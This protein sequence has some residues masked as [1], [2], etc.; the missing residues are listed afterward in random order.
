MTRR[1]QET[2]TPQVENRLEQMTKNAIS[3]TTAFITG[4]FNRER[5]NTSP[6]PSPENVNFDLTKQISD[7]FSGESFEMSPASIYQAGLVFKQFIL[8]KGVERNVL[9]KVGNFGNVISGMQGFEKELKVAANIKNSQALKDFL[10]KWLSTLPKVKNENQQQL[11][12][13]LKF[14][15][16]QIVESETLRNSSHIDIKD[17]LESISALQLKQELRSNSNSARTGLALTGAAILSGLASPVIAGTFTAKSAFDDIEK[18][19]R[20]RELGLYNKELNDAFD[21][22]KQAVGEIL[23]QSSIRLDNKQYI[24]KNLYQYLQ[25]TNDTELR[26]NIINLINAVNDMVEEPYLEDEEDNGYIDLSSFDNTNDRIIEIV[27]I[28]YNYGS[29]DGLK[30]KRFFGRIKGW[31]SLTNQ[32]EKWKQ[33]GKSVALL[34]ASLA[35]AELVKWAGGHIID[36]G[37]DLFQRTFGERVDIVGYLQHIGLDIN[38]NETLVGELKQRLIDNGVGGENS[39]WFPPDKVNAEK[40]AQELAPIFEALKDSNPNTDQLLQQLNNVF[41]NNDVV[42]PN[43]GGETALQQIYEG[44]I[45]EASTDVVKTTGGWDQLINTLSSQLGN[46]GWSGPGDAFESRFLAGDMN[47]AKALI[48]IFHAENPGVNLTKEALD[49]FVRE[50]ANTPFFKNIIES[51]TLEFIK[52]KNIWYELLKS[53]AVGTSAFAV[54]VGASSLANLKGANLPDM[55]E[56]GRGLKDRFNDEV[57]NLKNLLGNAI[58][59]EEFYSITRWSKEDL[60]ILENQ[61]L[62]LNNLTKKQFENIFKLWE[63]VMDKLEKNSFNTY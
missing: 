53:F 8:S 9:G 43:G 18:L 10:T 45:R 1:R 5:K 37:V 60:A 41:Q 33:A 29:K 44:L 57:E 47:T 51:K 25:F 28:Y 62:D 22:V 46:K 14:K 7:I 49:K 31:W 56:M 55:G 26:Q 16:E 50:N 23:N 48:Q 17:G 54:G 32:K 27:E 42:I 39:Q 11:A 3:T 59:D 2:Q 20:T 38:N 21:K 13:A 61:G 6:N 36:S 52:Q 34:G 30:D 58:T 35:G 40:M 63:Q 15:L 19:A 12:L 4:F 24:L